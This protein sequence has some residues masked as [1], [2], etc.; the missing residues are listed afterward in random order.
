LADAVPLLQVSV[1]AREHPYDSPK[2]AMVRRR[3]GR[4]WWRLEG[5]QVSLAHVGMR[6]SLVSALGPFLAR[7]EPFS[8]PGNLRVEVRTCS[9]P[10]SRSVLRSPLWRAL[11]PRRGEAFR[12]DEG[13]AAGRRNPPSRVLRPVPAM[14]RCSGLADPRKRRRERLRGVR[15]FSWRR[16]FGLRV[17]F[18]EALVRRFMNRGGRGVETPLLKSSLLGSFHLDVE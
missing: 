2:A 7:E 12:H 9:G 18:P 15:T 1:R 17:R 13:C 4:G 14:M 8:Y 5:P 6:R 10:R 11:L 16:L 3:L